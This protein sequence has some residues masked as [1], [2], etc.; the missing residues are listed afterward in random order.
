MKRW[1]TILCLCLLPILLFS[2]CAEATAQVD[3]VANK[4]VKKIFDD[5]H[6][7]GYILDDIR[8]VDFYKEMQPN[9]SYTKKQVKSTKL[10]T[11]VTKYYR[12]EDLVYAAYE[13]GGKQMTECHLRS[14]HSNDLT[15]TYTDADGKRTGVSI[16][17]ADDKGSYRVTFDQGL[18]TQSPYGADRF[19]IGSRRRR[20]TPPLTANVPTRRSTP[21]ASSPAPWSA[22]TTTTKRAGSSILPTPRTKTA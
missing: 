12:N 7:V 9:D 20:T 2:A 1:G 10:D 3:F 17:C 8:K 5:V 15:V 13:K 22:P 6:T 14:T 4:D 19:T 18:N 21:T 16:L 11:T